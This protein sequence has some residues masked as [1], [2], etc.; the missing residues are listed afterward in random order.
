MMKPVNKWVIA[1]TV[2]LPTL[3]E[4]LDIS[5]VNVSLDHIRGSLS[6]GVDEATWSIT[7]Y[8]V[9]NAIIIPLTGWL[10]RIIGRKRY[11]I[12]SVTLFTISSF[13]CG[14]A[15]SLSALVIFR[16]LQGIGGGGLQPLSQAILLES[17][18][19]AQYGIAMAVFGIG[20]MAGPIAGPVLGG[21]I[22]DNWSWPWIFYINIPLGILSIIMIN[23]F[24]HDPAYLKKLDTLKEKIDYWGVAL[25]VVGIGC[26]QIV[27][28]HGQREDWFSSR[29][30]MALAIISAMSLVL[31]I[32]VELNNR[33]PIL[34]L[35]VF[36]DLSFSAGTII[37]ACA[38][39]MYMGTLVMLPLYLQQLMGYNA[40]L[41][42]MILMPG[43]IG[44][45]LS[46]A[47]VGKLVE[48]VNPKLILTAGICIAAYSMHMLTRINLYI[49]Y[50]T[51]AWT[52]V[53]MGIGLGMLLVPLLSMSFSSIEQDA[54][55]NA[56][57][58]FTTL[59]T[60]SLSI[61]TA[62]VVTLFS[63]RCQFHQS[64]LSEVLNPYDSRFQLYSQKAAHTLML[65]NGA[66]SDLS[67]NFLIYQQLL[68]EAALASFV[69]SFFMSAIVVACALPL[70][71]FLKRPKEGT[72]PI[73]IH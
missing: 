43:G 46:M 72:A 52:R 35:R 51:I 26:L 16:V 73:P 31:F 17:F 70:V 64:R 53:I 59:R 39:S 7:A 68:R 61:G 36:R 11:L 67:N 30:I 18:P 22:T 58:I 28:D 15:T 13:L 48:K 60:I 8:L 21:W 49:D 57:G 62:F 23:L 44:M 4:V 50:G 63:R 33:E 1:L 14:S 38:F 45:L 56:T 66:T 19:P 10:S 47:I 69:D 27:L 29:M 71:F 40:L 25:I 5:V 24:I 2:I 65:K 37:Q 3:L 32:F 42:G 55:G 34:D 12:A 20:V 6:A 54:L 9:A 41:S